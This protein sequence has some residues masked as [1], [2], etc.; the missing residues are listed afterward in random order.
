MMADIADKWRESWCWNG[1]NYWCRCCCW[2]WEVAFVMMQRQVCCEQRESCNHWPVLC[3][4][5]TGN[6]LVI[7]SNLAGS[8][9]R[10]GSVRENPLQ[11]TLV[12]LLCLHTENCWCS[13]ENVPGWHT[14]ALFTNTPLSGKFL[15]HWTFWVSLDWQLFG[16]RKRALKKYH[17]ARTI[18]TIHLSRFLHCPQWTAVR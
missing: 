11:C 14:C 17:H 8:S 16:E 18:R 15:P 12:G 6:L 4:R 7:V 3:C 10:D 1:K 9:P 5:M 2:W 13:N